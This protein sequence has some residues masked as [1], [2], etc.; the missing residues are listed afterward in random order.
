M[1]AQHRHWTPRSAPQALHKVIRP[2]AHLAFAARRQKKSR[3]PTSRQAP[4]AQVRQAP[5]RPATLSVAP[6]AT[7]WARSNIRSVQVFIRPT[8]FLLWHR[9]TV[10]WNQPP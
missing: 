10:S 2:F 7:V 6:A 3:L 4:R 8:R 9:S 5:R 1:P